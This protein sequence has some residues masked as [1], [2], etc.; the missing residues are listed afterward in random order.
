MTPLNEKT[1]IVNECT[2]KRWG[3][4]WIVTG[5]EDETVYDPETKQWF[6]VEEVEKFK[7]K[8]F[9]FVL[10]WYY[11]NKLT[12]KKFLDIKP[13]P[14][15]ISVANKLYYQGQLIALVQQVLEVSDPLLIPQALEQSVA[16]LLPDPTRIE[17]LTYISEDKMLMAKNEY[18]N[19]KPLLSI[20]DENNKYVRTMKIK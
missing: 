4:K 15:L 12:N 14:V 5:F 11:W 19:S 17:F 18:W 3:N 7:R 6:T 13:R 10:I 8:P 2:V 9:I 1:F 16:S 20:M